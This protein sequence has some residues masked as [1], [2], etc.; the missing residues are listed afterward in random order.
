MIR[1]NVCGQDYGVT[2]VC[3]GARPEPATDPRWAPASG[4]APLRYLR[5]AVA[6]ARWDDA[7]ILAAS[8]DRAATRYGAVIWLLGQLLY[9]GTGL[10]VSRGTIRLGVPE[11]VAGGLVLVAFQAV[12]FLAQYGCCHLLARWLFGGRGTFRGIMRPMLLG[13]VVIWALP[14]PYVGA[15]V[16]ALWF[17]A[18]MMLV[19]ENVDGIG[20]LK[21]FALSTTFGVLFTL[22]SFALFHPR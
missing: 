2:H 13:S 4:F 1:C 15:L 17:L 16:A 5:Q 6:I 18:I 3:S 8:Q 22:A 19:F 10:W 14:I 21:A 9:L 7:A 11:L 12:I 20:R